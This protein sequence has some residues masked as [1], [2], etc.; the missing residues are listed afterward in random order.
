MDE[1]TWMAER[2]EAHRH[3]L[4]QVAQRL[5]GSGSDAADAIQETWLRFSR[6]DTTSVGNLGGW[7][8]TVVAR[9]SLDMLRARRSRREEPDADA[10]VAA[11]RHA[12]SVDP[13]QDA[14]TADA[15]G[16]ALMIVLERLAPAERVAFV[17]HDLFDMPFDDIARIID[18]ST[19][20]ARQLASRARRRVQGGGR[21]DVA[22]V[23]A[24]RRL[25]EAFLTASRE[26]DLA[27]LLAVLDPDVVFR[28]DA[29]AGRLGPTGPRVRGAETV[30]GF[31]KG[32]AQA[33]RAVLIDGT[34]GIEVAPHGRLLLVLRPTIVDGR[35]VDIE[36]VA[37]A[38]ALR[39]LTLAEFPS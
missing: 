24:E 28:A 30:A 26:G 14:R 3:H 38:E 31:F 12:D 10:D 9:V 27:G 36:A 19:V 39:R 20:A 18:R 32:R 1:Q 4:E 8:T 21:G 29:T 13:E 6:S 22:E 11:E 23:Q 15:V 5:L 25:V 2:F 7:L 37:D 33:A 16:M 17:L 34:V 35:I